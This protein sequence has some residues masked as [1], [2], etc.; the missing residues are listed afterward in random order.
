[1]PIHG[2]MVVELNRC[3]DTVGREPPLEM[4]MSI[5]SDQMHR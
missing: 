1:M 4:H 2:K 5:K 3:L